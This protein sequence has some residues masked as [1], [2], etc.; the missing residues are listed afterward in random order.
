MHRFHEEQGDRPL[1][2]VPLGL[3][4][5]RAWAFRSRV[6]VLVGRPVS[7]EFSPDQSSRERLLELKKRLR[8]ALEAL[9]ANFESAEAQEESEAL[10]YAA[11][12]GTKANYADTLRR[13]AESSPSSLAEPWK[14]LDAAAEHA[15]LWR[16]QGVPLFPPKRWHLAVYVLL[17]IPLG[18]VVGLAALLNLPIL[19]L[20][21]RT[22][23]KRADE[24]NVV[25]LI[26]SVSAFT[27]GPIWIALVG[28]TLLLAGVP[29]LLA[30]YLA[31]SV[32]GLLCTYRVKKLS[33][34]VRNGLCASSFR[35][36]AL[37][38]HESLLAH[39]HDEH[40][41]ERS[42]NRLGTIAPAPR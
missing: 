15:G 23:R 2:V 25:A 3:H 40:H 35:R 22:A 26:R 8:D 6:E 41:S 31:L 7:T 1:V 33:V 10:A 9:G 27:V 4:Y 18:A 39:E 11:T 28:A 19:S 36:R 24:R 34:S 20:A 32:I 42:A 37:R 29:T 38:F 30:A 13:F 14:D 16:H 5:E 17:L 21:A 12:V